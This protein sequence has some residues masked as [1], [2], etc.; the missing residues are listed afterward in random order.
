MTKISD[1]LLQ[2]IKSSYE[3]IQALIEIERIVKYQEKF[4]EVFIH[5]P[6]SL[7]SIPEFK[8]SL[9]TQFEQMKTVHGKV[10]WE[11]RVM[12]VIKSIQ[13]Q[14]STEKEEI[15][16]AL[17]PQE[18]SWEELPPYFNEHTFLALLSYMR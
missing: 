8:E 17:M 3:A 5:H 1:D 10:E 12:L 4:N 7:K 2:Q 15:L 16:Y 6:L 11:A 9:A 18:V 14:F 13:E